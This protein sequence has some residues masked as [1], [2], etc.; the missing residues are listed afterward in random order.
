MRTVRLLCP[1]ADTLLLSPLSRLPRKSGV[2]VPQG[3]VAARPPL[4]GKTGLPRSTPPPVDRMD[5]RT[6]PFLLLRQD[7]SHALQVPQCSLTLDLLALDCRFV[8]LSV[9][10]D[11]R[12]PEQTRFPQICFFQSPAGPYPA[13]KPVLPTASST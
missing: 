8:L 1:R 7:L 4:Q 12:V 6:T 11:P 13:E 5:Q 2:E 9:P 3:L 10:K